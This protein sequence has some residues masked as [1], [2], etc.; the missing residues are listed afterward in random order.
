MQ[1]FNMLTMTQLSEFKYWLNYIGNVSYYQTNIVG[2]ENVVQHYFS[3]IY[4]VASKEIYNTR[5]NRF[6]YQFVTVFIFDNK[7]DETQFML[8]CEH[9]YKDGIFVNNDLNIEI[10]KHTTQY[11]SEI[12]NILKFKH[13]IHS[14]S[15]PFA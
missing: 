4:G 15:A 10:I 13:Y 1:P 3:G 9:G 11:S 6:N 2:M 14:L 8:S 5:D 7:F 12:G